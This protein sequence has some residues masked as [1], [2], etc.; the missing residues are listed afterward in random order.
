M[1]CVWLDESREVVERCSFVAM[2]SRK[3][4]EA[5]NPGPVSLSEG[6]GNGE[7]EGEGEVDGEV[8]SG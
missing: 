6:E 7:D 2:G 1:W 5:R 8:E 3:G 4:G